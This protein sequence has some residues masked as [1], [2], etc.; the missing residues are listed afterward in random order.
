[1]HERRGPFA[2][3]DAFESKLA[4][5]TAPSDDEL[6]REIRARLS[7][8][9][10]GS[11]GGASKSQ[12]GTGRSCIVCSRTIEPIEVERRVEGSDVSLYAHE[13]CYKPWREESLARRAGTTEL[14]R[15]RARR[16]SL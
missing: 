6:R 1:V 10:L 3:R 7:E 5:T 15:E 9:R 12:R 14:G 13:A 2:G 4:V 16:G 11:V 8:G